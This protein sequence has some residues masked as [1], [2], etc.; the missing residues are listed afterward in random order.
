MPGEIERPGLDE[1]LAR[2]GRAREIDRRSSP[3]DRDAREG[4]S[5]HSSVRLPC[6][7]R[8]FSKA[9]PQMQSPAR[10]GI[11]Q[12]CP[13]PPKTQRSEN[14]TARVNAN[15]LDGMRP[16][17]THQIVPR[18][19]SSGGATFGRFALACGKPV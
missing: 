13:P 5:Q 8:N 14:E 9:K 16:R 1:T 11:I 18:E 3:K 12:S 10:A 2:W 17:Q 7:K 19:I 4:A 6:A 15:G